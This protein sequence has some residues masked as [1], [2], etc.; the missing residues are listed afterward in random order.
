[1]EIESCIY[2]WMEMASDSFDSMP[3]PGLGEID[4][5][6]SNSQNILKNH[7][8]IKR[9]TNIEKSLTILG[10]SGIITY[11]FE[12]RTKTKHETKEMI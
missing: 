10:N 9:I 7:N 2:E 1:M 11:V 3:F 6:T 5:Q 4:A 12:T 8:K